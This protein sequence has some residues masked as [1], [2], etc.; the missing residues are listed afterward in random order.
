MGSLISN[1]PIPSARQEHQ[2]RREENVG[3]SADCCHTPEENKH[4]EDDEHVVDPPDF[5]RPLRIADHLSERFPVADDAVG[6]DD[7]EET[8]EDVHRVPIIGE[9]RGAC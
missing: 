3:C 1:R 2:N 4:A 7:T 5:S 6:E 8:L 9:R